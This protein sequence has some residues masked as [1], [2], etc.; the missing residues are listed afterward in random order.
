MPTDQLVAT[1][2]LHHQTVSRLRRQMEADGRIPP[3]TCRRGRL[4][5]IR[6]GIALT[7]DPAFGVIYDGLNDFIA[8]EP[9]AA[10]VY[11]AGPD[12]GLIKV[13]YSHGLAERLETLRNNSPVPLRI[14]GLIRGGRALEQWAHHKLADHRSHSEWF[15]REAAR[16]IFH[17]L[18]TARPDLVIRAWPAQPQ[19][20]VDLPHVGPESFRLP[21]GWAS[22]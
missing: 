11:F 15:E 21:A 13:G 4:A 9:K 20:P 22:P 5:R 3:G 19:P 2:G 18:A 8:S 1:Y 7:G 17:R 12:S 14:F 10:V 16:S 6:D